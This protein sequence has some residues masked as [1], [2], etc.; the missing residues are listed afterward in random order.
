[1]RKLFVL[2]LLFAAVPLLAL[3]V[4]PEV[5][6]SPAE[7]APSRYA[8]AA[9][10]ATNGDVYVAVWTDLRASKETFAARVRADGTLLD[11]AG[12]RVAA[13]SQAGAVIW[14]GSAFLIAYLEGAMTYP[15]PGM[16]KVRALS[17][18]GTLGAPVD[19]FANYVL[20]QTYSMR[21]A[22]NGDSVLLVTSEAN[23]AILGPDGHQRRKL[24]F[25][26][27]FA[28]H[29]FGVAAAGSTYLV[30]AGT[31]DGLLKTQIVTA[32]GDFGVLRTEAEGD[33][34]GIEIASDGE[35][36][37]VVW[38]AGNLYAQF[39]TREGAPVEPKFAITDDPPH[40]L[41][42]LVRRG[43]EYV[44]VY[45]TAGDPPYDTLRL[46]DNGEKRGPLLTD[47]E[48]EID[49][50][51]PNGEG[52]AVLGRKDKL[53]TAAFFDAGTP[54]AL[55]NEA[56]VSF[57]GR[58]Q[59]QV[60]LAA[61]VDGMVA[62][63]V[64]G[65]AGVSEVR[66]SR[67][68][69][70]TPV[71]VAEGGEQSLIDV[72]VENGTIWVLWVRDEKELYARRF[73]LELQAVDPQPVH[74]A[75][76][77][78][79]D[80][81]LELSAAGGGGAVVVVCDDAPEIPEPA[82]PH[83]RAY[84]LR[85]ATSSIDVKTVAVASE[86]GHDHHPAVAWNGNAFVI[87]WANATS[88]YYPSAYQPDDRILMKRMSANGEML[89]A[90]STEITRS[91]HLDEL[92]IANGAIVWQTYQTPNLSSRRHTYAAR[93]VANATVIDLGGE[94]TFFGDLASDDGGLILTRM[95]TA[96]FY[97]LEPE[98]LTLD[99]SLGVTSSVALPPIPGEPFAPGLSRFDADVI[100][101]ALRTIAYSRI[102]DAEYGHA[103]RVFVRRLTASHRRRP[104][105][106]R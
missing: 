18:D 27:L 58:R 86:T 38:A 56:P 64:F 3:N 54:A 30:A 106:L 103:A 82:S 69:G 28:Q 90:S 45:R 12:I 88:Y 62:A 78:T 22:T 53:L 29:G 2:A 4:L 87:A 93:A 8:T 34:S 76:L 97:T 44:L 23:G 26:W 66:L 24:T 36:F 101:G 68:P 60:R 63:W 102:S 92:R 85:A 55:G 50:I 43:G 20:P 19:M 25:P 17:P 6:L 33:V 99:A 89:D 35:R 21:M 39:V 37:L 1:M 75:P 32:E 70:S 40:G 10:I 49:D 74:V 77:P 98:V 83:I 95:K 105:R 94:D 51:V 73:T 52:G 42:R 9:G 91:V 84:V 41:I 46:S 5:P 16:V 61:A 59:S 47:F 31:H 11:P 14:S 7:F 71:L 100:G 80:D 72:V 15:E 57:S 48:G 96:D 104:L 65:D 81:Y 67:G 79:F 13:N